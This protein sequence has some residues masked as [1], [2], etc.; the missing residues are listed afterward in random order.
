MSGPEPG[1]DRLTPR[2]RVFVPLAA[3]A[4]VALAFLTEPAI[5]RTTDFVKHWALNQAYIRTRLLAG[6][7]PLWTP[8]VELGRPFL[9]SIDTGVL[10]PPG[11]LTVLLGANFGAALLTAAHLAMAAVAVFKLGAAL[12]MARALRWLAALAFVAGTHL[13][14]NIHVG[15]LQYGWGACY[16]PLAFWLGVRVQDR[17]SLRGVAALALT[18]ALQILSGLPQ[19][20]WNGWLGLGAFLLGR[21]IGAGPSPRAALKPAAAGLGAMALAL[22]W[23]F[24]ASAAQLLPLFELTG[25]SNRSAPTVAAADEGS[26]AFHMWLSLFVPPD[27][28]SHVPML[29]ALFLGAPVVLAGACGL[30][31][32]RDRNV[33]GLVL[34]AGLAF[35]VA[36]GDRTPAFR[37]L[38]HVVPGLSSFHFH[39]RASIVVMFSLVLAG[40]LF[41]TRSA[42]RTGYAV[43][44]AATLALLLGTLWWRANV[45][46]PGVPAAT[47]LV[48]R[49]AMILAAAG[50]IALWHLRRRAF[51]LGA[52][53]LLA[54]LELGTAIAMIKRVGVLPGPFPGEAAVASML[55]QAGLFDPAGVPP[56][57][58]LPYPLIRDN[59]GLQYRYSTVAGYVPL[60]LSRVWGFLHE[61]LGVAYPVGVNEFP[62]PEIFAHGPF[63]YDCMNI[64]LG[65]DAGDGQIHLRHDPD[66]RAYVAGA[67]QEVAGWRDA[68]RRMREGHDFHRVALLEERPPDPLD[69]ASGRAR[70]TAFRPE[71]LEVEVDSSGRGLLVLAEPWYPGW[72]ATVNGAAAPVLPANAWMRAV[73]V[74]S[75]PSRVVLA[76]CSRYLP[77]GALISV[78]AV[79]ALGVALLSGRRRATAART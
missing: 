60:G 49:W 64:V 55:R 77:A 4:Y 39:G 10:Y 37:V 62:S 7:L 31:Q 52:V 40:G 45:V 50:A 19:I 51:G 48:Y 3:G 44:V 73:P 70:I 21:G 43:L 67:A 32:V 78:A 75:G 33:R 23:A 46:P 5:F 34:A 42:A 1:A 54:A 41:L 28:V 38:F 35:L 15:A 57:V 12:G 79:A 27:T 76:Y 61:R 13:F 63:A 11:L 20:A 74:P 58:L 25:Q 56:R 69:G 16:I 36:A 17:F 47:W 65:W 2:E 72:R 9:A 8:D 24:L 59:S 30:T 6:E 14:I 71:R 68:V 53:A 18:L 26:L 22:A 29:A 66:P